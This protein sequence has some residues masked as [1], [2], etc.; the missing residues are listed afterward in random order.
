MGK[1]IA[2]GVGAFFCV[3]L[4]VLCVFM[5]IVSAVFGSE[6]LVSA[7]GH[8]LYI[9][10]KSDFDGITDGSAVIVSQCEP[11]DV[12]EGKLI[13]YSAAGASEEVVPALGY[14]ENIVMK[15]G[16]YSIDITDGNGRQL[17]ISES[18]FIGRAGWSSE[19][20]GRFITFSKT[21]IGICIIAVLPCV[22]LIIFTFVRSA[23]ENAPPP[24]V[25]PQVKNLERDETVQ[26]KGISVKAD[27]KAEYG[28][29][30]GASQ[31][32]ADSVLFTYDANGKRR[33]P[34]SKPA[35]QSRPA[36]PKPSSQTKPALPAER[37]AEVRRPAESRGV[38]QRRASPAA[39]K[40][41]NVPS[42]VAAKRY[43]ENAV[44]PAQKSVDATAEMPQLPKKPKSD[45][46]FAQSEA[47]QIGRRKS[48]AAMRPS[49]NL[50]NPSELRGSQPASRKNTET[51]QIKSADILAAKNRSTL[52]T[53]DD[54]SR[55]RSR[56]DVDDIL[57][58]INRRV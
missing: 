17:T 56:Y 22:A 46:F 36:Q 44:K 27:G 7:F 37:S 42:P 40:P 39:M 45:A 49:V 8:N 41:D 52:I 48:P 23:V 50:D 1:K 20:L 3:L 28:R 53:D 34:V 5:I 24:E 19:F 32:S 30:G 38:E 57:S 2:R 10:E 21:P 51:T 16:V 55:D 47:P 4:F 9:C 18:A 15:D 12:T 25:I 6:G 14:T 54:D 31:K 33:N 13:L 11:Y 26:N 43:T 29:T 58:G 35:P